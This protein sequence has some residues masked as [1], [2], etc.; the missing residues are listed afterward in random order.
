MLLAIFFPISRL[1]QKLKYV[2]N[3][4]EKPVIVKYFLN[5]LFWKLIKF[6]WE[7]KFNDVK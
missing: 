6:T 3:F 2:L 4:I 7:N 5:K 1:A